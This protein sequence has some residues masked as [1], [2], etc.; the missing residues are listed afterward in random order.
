MIG[1][2]WFSWSPEACTA[3]DF[4]SSLAPARTYFTSLEVGCQGGV[5]QQLATSARLSSLL[6]PAFSPCSKSWR[7]GTRAFCK[8]AQTTSA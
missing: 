1:Q 6:T 5:Q 3:D 2:Q 4:V 7:S 8:P